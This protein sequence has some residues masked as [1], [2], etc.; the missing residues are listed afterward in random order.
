[1]EFLVFLV[2]GFL[3]FLFIGAILGMRAHARQGTLQQRVEE[4]EKNLRQTQAKLTQREREANAS[5]P[6]AKTSAPSLVKYRAE[7]ASAPEEKKSE[8]PVMA[9]SLPPTST[10]AVSAPPETPLPTSCIPPAIISVPPASTV[11]SPPR[12]LVKPS[13]DEQAF[14]GVEAAVGLR[15]LTW[16][17]VGLVFLALAF[18]L[19]YA[20]DQDWLGRVFTPP[21]RIA[22]VVVLAVIMLGLGWRSLRRGMTALGQGLV[23]GGLA[24]LYLA[25]YAAFQ[26]ALLVVREPLISA[27]TAFALMALVTAAGLTLAV[28]LDALAI[29]FLAVIGGFAAPVLVSSG[30]DARDVL[31]AYLLLLDVGVLGVAL[32][33]RWR[34]LDVLAFAGT[35]LLFIGWFV[36]WYHHQSTFPNLATLAWL[37]VFHVIFLL[38]P[39]AHHWR[40][41][42]PVTL[43]R[44]AL[45]LANLAW[46]LGYAAYILQNEAQILL[47]VLCLILAALYVGL[48]VVTHRSIGG[49]DL[50][51]LHGFVALATMLLTLGLFYLLPVDGITTAWFV[52]ATALLILGY[53]FSYAPTRWTALA[54]LGL[55]L[56]R[57]LVVHLPAENNAADLICNR[58]FTMLLVAA[59]GPAAIALVHWRHRAS[60]LER[61]VAM[62]C[63]VLAGY[64]LIGAASLEIHRHAGGHAAS[65]QAIIQ[66][67]AIAW[68]NIL[69]SLGFLYWA[70]RWQQGAALSAALLPLVIALSLALAA[71]EYYAPGTWLA[72]NTWA[73]TALTTCLTLGWA[74]RLA[75]RQLALPQLGATLAGSVQLVLVVVLTVEALAWIQ[76]GPRPPA[77]DVPCRVLAW[78]WILTALASS[79]VAMAWSSRR[80]LIIGFLPLVGGLVTVL[81]LYD[82]SW[83]SQVLVANS[84]FLLGLLAAG[85][86]AW[87]GQVRRDLAVTGAIP[88]TGRVAAGAALA[89]ILFIA[90][91]EAFSWSREQFGHGAEARAWCVWLIGAA[92]LLG[93]VGGLWRQRQRADAGLSAVGALALAGGTLLAFGLF[94]LDWPAAWMF[95]NLRFMLALAAV[96][97]LVLYARSAMKYTRLIWVAYGVGLIA[98]TCEPPVWLLAHIADRHEAIKAATFS[99][100]VVWVLTAVLSL[101]VGFRWDLRPVRLA[102]LG[103]FALTA[104]K[105]LLMDMRG[106]Q[107]FYRILAFL[108]VG[109]VFIAASWLYHQAE[110]RLKTRRQAARGG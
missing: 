106:A 74:S 104:A 12:P 62:G 75:W 94:G 10:P 17:G 70:R 13:L 32:Y 18:F 22:T 60:G 46:S 78:V 2:L 56:M 84:R 36:T 80:I 38:L 73:C 98:L 35:A 3:L 6:A 96:A 53:R 58:W 100:T 82:Y 109:V 9:V 45:A 54:L 95:V 41:R 71:Y 65:W 55:A 72:F 93:S 50:R 1:M 69:G 25:V 20:Y 61:S 5:E 76:S 43:E 89:Y 14:A 24:L 57:T 42:T 85:G 11:V 64:L 103:L 48:G 15:W 8:P 47:A 4:L 88:W 63:G 90:V 51:T 92:W 67:H 110:Q 19:K 29:A 27:A 52:E 79:L 102:A 91:W 59:A 16:T 21:M 31:F 7:S 105:L 33:R 49:G 77:A 87:Y 107:Q 83:P 34:M 26:P 68:L 23:G 86:V 108:V 39:F 37:G 81:V 40:H 99:V 44:F 30:Q 101:G 66:M 97:A 28:R